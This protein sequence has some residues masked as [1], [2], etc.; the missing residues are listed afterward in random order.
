MQRL[1][2]LYFLL[3]PCFLTVAGKLG[4]VLLNRDGGLILGGG[5]DLLSLAQSSSTATVTTSSSANGTTSAKPAETTLSGAN[6]LNSAIFVPVVVA[7]ISVFVAICLI[8]C[9]RL[10]IPTKYE[11]TNASP[12]NRRV[13]D[14]L[15]ETEKS[16]RRC[17]C[18]WLGRKP[19]KPQTVWPHSRCKN[20]R[21]VFEEPPKNSEMVIGSMPD[22]PLSQH[23]DLNL[24]GRDEVYSGMPADPLDEEQEARIRE[25]LER[26]N[27][28]DRAWASEELI[29]GEPT[30]MEMRGPGIGIAS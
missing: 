19:K 10:R 7:S 5:I 21:A 9:L 18:H 29:Y 2:L 12:D 4:V 6:K 14:P 16:R 25:M 24:V 26:M 15:W 17:Q 23:R 3:W 20:E 13:E 30:E 1:I 28:E 27:P 22:L 8:I 11:D